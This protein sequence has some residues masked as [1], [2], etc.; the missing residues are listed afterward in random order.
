[1]KLDEKIEKR[2]SSFS[3]TIFLLLKIHKMPY[4]SHVAKFFLLFQLFVLH[5]SAFP[6]E[7]Q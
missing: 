6:Y 7:A 2:R 1:M 4:L 5:F 3:M